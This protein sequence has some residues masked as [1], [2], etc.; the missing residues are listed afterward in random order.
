MNQQSC[1]NTMRNTRERESQQQHQQET[2][3]K[4]KPP[5]SS[6]CLQRPPIQ[7]SLQ[8]S[9]HDD[10][11]LEIYSRAM[12][13]LDAADN[14]DN[15]MEV[16][17]NA[18]SNLKSQ[19]VQNGE[20][21]PRS[22]MDIIHPSSMKNHNSNWDGA[23]ALN[24]FERDYEGYD[25]CYKGN[26]RYSSAMAE[27]TAKRVYGELYSDDNVSG[28][29]EEEWEEY[30][31]EAFERASYTYQEEELQVRKEEYRYA[32]H[33]DAKYRSHEPIE[34]QC[35]SY[36]DSE[37]IEQEGS[38]ASNTMEIEPGMAINFR[39]SQDTW[40]AVK[41]NTLLANHCTD[42]GQLL[43]CINDVDYFLCPDCDVVNPLEGTCS[44]GFDLSVGLGLRDAEV[45]KWRV[46]YGLI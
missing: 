41:R 25:D 40:E 5:P 34:Q 31:P 6:C 8:V 22:V 12:Q 33:H 19:Q 3:L 18:M 28:A 21:P 27:T 10:D 35:D 23:H 43:H 39:G 4:K 15:V 24:F 11:L 29:A 7:D 13:D 17:M 37:P 44:D 9:I 42:C 16:Y 32:S 36:D 30:D 2:R 26:H 45:R 38:P 14:D 20:T 1:K 46:E